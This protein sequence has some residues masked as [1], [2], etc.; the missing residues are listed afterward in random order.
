M[1]ASIMVTC[2]TAQ[3]DTFAS[4]QLPFSL[5]SLVFFLFSFLFF[6][7]FGGGGGAQHV[8]THLHVIYNQRNFSPQNA[9]F[10]L[11]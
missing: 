4:P 7:F 3:K 2:T 9:H 11:I 1:V 8:H 6:L 5:L 10:L